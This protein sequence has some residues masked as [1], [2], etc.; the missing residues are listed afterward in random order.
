MYGLTSLT[1]VCLSENLKPNQWS[2]FSYIAIRLQI[3]MYESSILISTW[4]RY[5]TSGKILSD[6]HT[7]NWSVKIRWKWKWNKEKTGINLDTWDMDNVDIYSQ[8][9]Y[10]YAV[11]AN[12]LEHTKLVRSQQK[13][14]R[15]IPAQCHWQYMACE[16]LNSNRRNVPNQP[17]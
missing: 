2:K 4:F 10:S 3:T 14:H 1:T 15:N 8:D 13:C 16:R 6:M 12:C 17:R 9:S 11:I 7:K 5:W